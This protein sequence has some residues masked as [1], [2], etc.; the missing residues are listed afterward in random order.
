MRG[1]PV[2]KVTEVSGGGG[3]EVS[4]TKTRTRGSVLGAVGVA[5][6]AGAGT[7]GWR[8]PHARIALAAN[9]RSQVAPPTGSRDIV[10]I[11]RVRGE[12]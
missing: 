11:R 8:P 10:P 1:L 6:L 12:K 3:P 4:S 9:T 2:V 7:D 5:G